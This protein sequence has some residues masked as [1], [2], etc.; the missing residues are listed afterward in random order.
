MRRLLRLDD[1]RPLVVIC[2]FLLAALPILWVSFPP[3]MDFPNHLV[4]VWL[5]GGGAEQARLSSMYEVSWRQASTNLGVDVAAAGLARLLPIMTV[6]KILLLM[7]FLGPPLGCAVLHKAVF[8]RLHVWPIAFL[9]LALTTTAIA[10][11]IS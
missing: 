10:G 7:M 1:R 6:S 2:A 3:V 11:F 5:L 4:R 8:G 9:S